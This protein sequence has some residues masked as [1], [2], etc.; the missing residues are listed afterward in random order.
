MFLHCYTA[1]PRSILHRYCFQS[2]VIFCSSRNF[3]ICLKQMDFALLI[4]IKN[5]KHLLDIYMDNEIF[6]SLW[7]EYFF[8]YH[9]HSNVAFI[10]HASLCKWILQCIIWNIYKYMNSKC[11]SSRKSYIYCLENICKIMK[12][13]MLFFGCF[14]DI[15]WGIYILLFAKYIIWCDC[16]IICEICKYSFHGEYKGFVY[17]NTL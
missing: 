11:V 8:V 7:E 16:Y 12:K 14:M 1:A 13:K 4:G 5:A 6:W 17:L 15:F 3:Y 10:V 9:Q 2:Q